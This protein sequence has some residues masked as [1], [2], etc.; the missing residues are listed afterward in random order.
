MLRPVVIE[1]EADFS[2]SFSPLSLD[3]DREPFPKAFEGLG[4]G[5]F[6]L[7]CQGFGQRV[8]ENI[9]DFTQLPPVISEPI[10]ILYTAIDAAIQ[11]EYLVPIQVGPCSFGNGLPF[12][13]AEAAFT[14]SLAEP[15]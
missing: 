12:Y 10:V 6:V 7:V 5:D 14:Q 2:V 11:L 15:G 13:G 1:V 3:C 4:D 9:L 8:F